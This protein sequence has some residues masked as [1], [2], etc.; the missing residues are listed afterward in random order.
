MDINKLYNEWLEKAVADSDLIKELEAIKGSED[1]I[2]DRTDA[3]NSEQ[4]A[5]AVLSVQAQT[6]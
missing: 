4:Q 5:C 6:E 3:L 1:E 2:S